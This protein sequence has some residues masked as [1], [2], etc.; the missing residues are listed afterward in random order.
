MPDKGGPDPRPEGTAVARPL[1]LSDN[2]QRMMRIKE[3][4][5]MSITSFMFHDIRNNDDIRFRNRYT[6]KPF[7]T[8]A[9]FTTQ[10]DFIVSNYKII[11]TS[12]LFSVTD[13]NQYAIL[14][15]DDG[16]IDHYHIQPLLKD[17]KIRG[18]F[19]VPAGILLHNVVMKSHKIQFV[20]SAADEKQLV[21]EILGHVRDHD[22]I[23]ERFSHSRFTDNWWTPEMV[24]VTNFLRNYEDH[25]TTSFIVD[26]L[27]DKY[28][29]TDHGSFARRFYLNHGQIAEMIKNGMEIGGHGYYSNDLTALSHEDQQT[30]I[31]STFEYIKSLRQ[32][33]DLFFSYPNGGFDHNTIALMKQNHC[34][35][36]YTTESTSV[37]RLEDVDLLRFPR[38]SAPETLRR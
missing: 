9:E 8:V 19:L 14:T 6:L 36:A 7:L 30:D 18:T 23:W 22:A 11:S 2:D 33:C 35:V 17:Y 21:R 15:F 24:F 32:D 12:E 5:S 4:T 26:R 34:K 31:A 1:A 20:L 3:T 25:E 29:S 38:I 10:L 27:F 13:N 28:V 16:L 37:D